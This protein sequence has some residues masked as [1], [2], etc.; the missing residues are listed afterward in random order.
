VIAPAY[1]ADMAPARLR[2]RL[3]IVLGIFVALLIDALLSNIAGSAADELALGGKAQRWMFAIAAVPAI[4]YGLISLT[5]PESPRYLVRR[6]DLGQAR[7]TLQKYVGGDTENRIKDIQHSLGT[8]AED[9]RLGDLRGPL[10][11]LLPIV[12]TGILLSIFQQ[13]VGI[14]VIFYYSTTLGARSVSRRTTRC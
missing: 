14:N 11:G 1:I 4:V 10:L 6:G 12:W 2:G 9:V 3:G 5:I 7:T 13:F 8:R